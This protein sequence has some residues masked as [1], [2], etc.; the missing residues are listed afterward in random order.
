[1]ATVWEE[2]YDEDSFWMRIFGRP[3]KGLFDEYINS[4]GGPGMVA[5]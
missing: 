3:V 5:E 4:L 1:M 2:E